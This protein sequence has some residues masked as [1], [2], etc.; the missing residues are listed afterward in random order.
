MLLH[1]VRSMNKNTQVVPQS[2]LTLK[3]LSGHLAFHPSS[4]FAESGAFWLPGFKKK[5]R[6]N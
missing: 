2:L 4:Q 1:N 6:I 3:P 5:T